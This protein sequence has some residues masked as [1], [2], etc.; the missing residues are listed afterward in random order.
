MK[1][2]AVLLVTLF[3][4][5]APVTQLAA[6]GTRASDRAVEAL[7]KYLA[8]PTDKR[9]PLAEQE[10]SKT[11]LTVDDAQSAGTMLWKDHQAMIQGIVLI[12]L[13]GK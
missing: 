9:S 2:Y 6:A 7:A 1:R 13:G 4:F 11:A 5:C 10:F 3:L 12:H 8:S